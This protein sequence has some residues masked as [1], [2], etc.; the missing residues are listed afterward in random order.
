ML[1]TS[2]SFSIHSSGDN[3]F[4][5]SSFSFNPNDHASSDIPLHRNILALLLSN[6]LTVI[7]KWVK[8]NLISSDQSKMRQAVI[9]RKRNQNFPCILMNGDELDTSTSFTQLGLSLSLIYFGK[10]TCIPLPG[11]HLKSSVSLP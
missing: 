1:L 8:D 6:D 7:E 5:S 3:T 4:L 11:M 2:T 10:F 9:S